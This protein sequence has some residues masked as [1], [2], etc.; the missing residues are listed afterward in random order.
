M[1]VFILGPVVRFPCLDFSFHSLSRVVVLC[2]KSV[3]RAPALPYGKSTA[4]LTD[5]SGLYRGHQDWSSM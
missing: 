3:Q 4:H 2:S 5:S 1:A